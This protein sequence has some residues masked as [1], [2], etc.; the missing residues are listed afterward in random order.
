[1]FGVKGK[2]NRE[3]MRQVRYLFLQ[4]HPN[5]I[6]S[7]ITFVVKAKIVLILFNNLKT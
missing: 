6:I 2:M 5:N 3:L 7:N 4:F 1:M